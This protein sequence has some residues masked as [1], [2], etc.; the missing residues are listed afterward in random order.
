M[1]GER[2]LIFTEEEY[3]ELLRFASERGMNP[4]E[5]ILAFVRL[6]NE[7]SDKGRSHWTR[8]NPAEKPR[9]DGDGI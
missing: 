9:P 6:G 8:E 3:Q 7:V 1:A 4:K 2:R 5:A